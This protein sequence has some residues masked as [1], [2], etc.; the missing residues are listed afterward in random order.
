MLHGLGDKTKASRLVAATAAVKDAQVFYANKRG[1]KSGVFL[2]AKC[3]GIA[4]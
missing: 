4:G 2:F 1:T 3:C